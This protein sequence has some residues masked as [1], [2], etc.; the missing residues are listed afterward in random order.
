[1][2]NLKNRGVVSGSSSVKLTI[3]KERLIGGL[4]L[5][6][7]LNVGEIEEGESLEVSKSLEEV[8]QRCRRH[9]PRLSEEKLC[10]RC[11]NAIRT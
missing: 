2:E 10:A 1:M 6:K 8:C 9:H 3:P 4:N 11:A 7:L 5:L